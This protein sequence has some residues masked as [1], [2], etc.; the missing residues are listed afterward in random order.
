MKIKK[1]YLQIWIAALIVS[2]IGA[3]LHNNKL[4]EPED[5]SALFVTI[6]LN[7]DAL[8]TETSSYE[9]H[10]ASEHFSDV[11]LGWT[12]EPS[13]SEEFEYSFVGRR[14]EKQNL[15]FLVDSPEEGHADALGEALQ[16]R[17][18]EYNENTGAAYVLAVQRTSIVEQNLSRARVFGGF[19]LL[20]MLLTT[21]LLTLWEY[22]HCY[23]SKASH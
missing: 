22:A 23:R 3:G 2:L 11:V 19:V 16:V 7:Q 14:Q 9:I 20:I 6:G 1:L 4:E 18:D 8:N 10:R 17:I 13:F 21:G 15:L 5:Q 12:V